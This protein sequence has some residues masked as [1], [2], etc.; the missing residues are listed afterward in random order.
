MIEITNLKIW[1][2]LTFVPF[3]KIFWKV[4]FTVVFWQA[5]RHTASYQVPITFDLWFNQFVLGNNRHVVW[6]VHASS[7]VL[8]PHNI[9]CGIETSPGYMSGCYIQG[10]GGIHF[11]DYTQ[12]GP[13]VSV[14]SANHDLTDTHPCTSPP[15]SSN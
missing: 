13:N 9:Y 3:P 2:G 15:F 1:S 4:Y 12:I 11:G 14:I 5:I 10:F 7:T 8:A 6:P